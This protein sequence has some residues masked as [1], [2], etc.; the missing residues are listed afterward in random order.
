MYVCHRKRSQNLPKKH[1]QGSL[2]AAFYHAGG[3]RVG[4]FRG[5]FRL[6]GWRMIE[7]CN[8][9]R[10]MV[11]KGAD[12]VQK[13]DWIPLL[14]LGF[15]SLFLKWDQHKIPAAPPK[16]KQWFLFYLVLLTANGS[17][18]LV[19]PYFWG[20][21]Q[22]YPAR[23]SKTR[24]KCVDMPLGSMVLLYLPTFTIKESAIR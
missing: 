12:F 3:C 10:N 23:L 5:V 16:R 1:I 11:P 2:S 21:R 15:D 8:L 7:P 22:E 6:Q 14:W 13:F 19:Q 18:G 4:F 24:F 17:D 20:D 9:K